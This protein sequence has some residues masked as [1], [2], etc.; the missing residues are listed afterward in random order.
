MP[1]SI[2]V[3]RFR[4]SAANCC[5]GIV[6][7]LDK[8]TS[9]C[10]VAAKSDAAHQALSRQFAGRQV[11]KIY[12]A[13]AS[14]RFAHPSGIIE[15]AI[16]RH[17]VHRKKMTVVETGKGRNA[18]TGWRVLAEL[19][20]LADVGPATLLECTLHTGRTH[21]IRVHLKHLGHPLLGDEVY[22]KRGLYPRQMLHA[23]GSWASGIR[24]MIVEM[25]FTAP[26]PDDFKAA[27]VEGSALEAKHPKG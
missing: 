27:G 5:P 18:R 21:Q 16:G 25:L 23:R 7:R 20:S 22:G 24:A 8:E 26:I 14:G 11:T 1:S 10:L 4:E 9:G 19:R 13:L 3:G 15:A 17:A 6:H 2:I 12:L